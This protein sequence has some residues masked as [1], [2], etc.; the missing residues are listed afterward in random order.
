MNDDF[1]LDASRAEQMRKMME[2]LTEPAE[3]RVRSDGRLETRRER[4][5]RERAA[6]K[7]MRKAA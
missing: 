2:Q 4:R 6:A 1:Y 7:Q 5:A 3:R